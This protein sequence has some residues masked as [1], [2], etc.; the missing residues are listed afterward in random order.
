MKTNL[1]RI[2]LGD[3][4]RLEALDIRAGSEPQPRETCDTPANCPDCGIELTQIEPG[5]AYCPD[6][7]QDLPKIERT[8]AD[9]RAES[10]IDPKPSP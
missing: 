7:K 4:A 10:Y 6:C 3:P 9:E 5:L 8:W 2:Y 1:D